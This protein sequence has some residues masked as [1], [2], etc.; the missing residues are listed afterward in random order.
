M[1]TTF[2]E[3]KDFLQSVLYKR[4]Y[5]PTCEH[6]KNK[7][8]IS[9]DEMNKVL[10]EPKEV[11]TERIIIDIDDVTKKSKAR[12]VPYKQIVSS[13]INKDVYEFTCPVCGELHKITFE[14][15]PKGV[16][17]VLSLKHNI[18]SLSNEIRN[19]NKRRNYTIAH[20][21]GHIVLHS[22]FFDI[23]DKAYEYDDDNVSPIVSEEVYKRME[24]QAN[25]FASYLLIPEKK[26]F[27]YFNKILKDLNIHK[28]HLYLDSQPCNINDVNHALLKLSEHFNISKEAVKYR[29]KNE[30]LLIIENNEPQRIRSMFRGY[31]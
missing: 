2:K 8:F 19:D 13:D 6:C 29:L 14:D 17:G 25:L 7:L 18:I 5:T 9:M 12:T 10:F 11:E 20:E 30:K 27:V 4:Y 1:K 15:F 16:L 28:K 23:I 26:L 22:S 31:R 21:I 3:H 24:V